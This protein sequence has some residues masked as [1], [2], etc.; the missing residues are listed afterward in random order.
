M[1]LNTEL[2]TNIHNKFKIEVR[3]VV[4][5]EIKQEGFAEN[6]VLDRMY[7]RLMNFN[8][9]FTYIHVGGGTGT[10]SPD[11]TTLFNPVTHKTAVDDE[12]IKDYP[13][14]SV[15]KKIE[16]GTTEQNGKTFT[17][18]GI[19]ESTN[20]I[21]THALIKD[22][23]GNPLS[24]TKTDIDVVT[25]YATIYFELIENPNSDGK[26]N[27]VATGNKLIDYVIDGATFTPSLWLGDEGGSSLCKNHINYRRSS[28]SLSRSSDS[29][30]RKNTYS[31]RIDVN[32]GN[33]D[34]GEIC[35]DNVYR[36]DLENAQSWAGHTLQDVNIGTGDGVTKDFDIGRYD[37][38]G[39]TAKIDSLSTTGYTLANTAG[40]N[41]KQHF[42]VFK[43]AK[44][45]TIVFNR[46]PDPFINISFDGS[47]SITSTVSFE[48][49]EGI[50]L[51]NYKVEYFT[52]RYLSYY[53]A[54]DIY[55][56]QDGE[57]YSKIHSNPRMDGV[58]FYEFTTNYK[59][60]RFYLSTSSTMRID[61]IRLVNKNYAEPTITFTTPPPEGAPITVS[62]TVP[63]IPKTE[64]Y[65]I[66]LSLD[67]HW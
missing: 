29:A 39:L 38:T 6:I 25:I 24:I 4:T 5:K 13:I 23:E 17:E 28:L 63:Y 3:N 65:V 32:E 26:F 42:P 37:F 30:N 15:T 51:T 54:T 7:T 16:F 41:Y 12:K 20:A 11:R 34:I 35:L 33:Y 57:V 40:K 8:P 62:Y 52:K 53:P 61:Y 21:N 2:K 66:D 59:Y 60:L 48:V 49:E 1:K 47:T 36:I 44:K 27:R 67:L 55:G 43:I 22:A 31:T 58:N 50:D 45:E 56:S 14:S 64:D 19:S 18:V 10:L 46:F 9:F